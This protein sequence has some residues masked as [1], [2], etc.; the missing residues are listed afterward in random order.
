L[1]QSDR[2]LPAP[3]KRPLSSMTPTI[4]LDD[5]GWVEV[6][7]GASGGPRIITA[8]TQCILNVLVF[9]DPPVPAVARGRLHHQW[10]PDVLFMEQSLHDASAS[11]RTGASTVADEMRALGHKVELEKSGASVQML[12]NGGGPGTRGGGWLAACDPRKGG[13]PAG[14]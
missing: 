9:R 7:A 12:V 8:T 5:T 13:K 2:N 10:S 1:T 14:R 6:V 4:V 3:G 11:G